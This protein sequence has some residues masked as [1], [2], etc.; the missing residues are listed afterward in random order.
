M[1]TRPFDNLTSYLHRQRL[2][3]GR[4]FGEG[5]RTVG[6]CKHIKKEL[7]EIQ[8]DPGDLTEW[9]DAVILGFD[10]AWRAG[11]EPE[12]IVERLA[13]KQAM[14]FGR[15]WPEPGSE[16]EP[17]E[18]V[19]DTERPVITQDAAYALLAKAESLA[20]AI[21]NGIE[22]G[23]YPDILNAVDDIDKAISDA[24]GES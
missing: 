24:K 17:T 6:I 13:A 14:N 12:E 20:T 8:A 1:N 23:R 22:L 19:R 10:G 21:D 9:L 5:K 15:T 11:Y 2:W 3:S 7:V 4:T 18:H 16:D